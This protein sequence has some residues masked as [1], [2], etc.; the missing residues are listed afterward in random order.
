MKTEP[1]KHQAIG[2]AKMDGKRNFAALMEQGTGK[3][4]LIMADAERC[5][6]ANKIDALLVIAPNGVHTNWVK[7][8]I[9]T[10]MSIE[11]KSY[12]WKGTPTSKKRQQE[13]EDFFAPWHLERRRPLMV[14]SI[15]IDSVNTKHG[16]DV[17]ERFIAFSRTMAVVDEST[18]IKN[19]K[20]L[21]TKK[22]IKLGRNA[23]CRRIL[24]GT[25]M[26]KS[27][28]DLF[29]QFDFLK[30]G[31]L[32][33]K[34]LAAFTAEYAVLMDMDDPDMQAIMRNLAGKVHGMPQVVKKDE[35]GR[36]MFK[37]LARL[38]AMIEPHSYRVKKEDC[39]DLPPKVYSPIFFELSNKQKDV[40]KQLEIE[41]EYLFQDSDSGVEENMS[42]AAIAARTKMKQV[43]SGFINIYGDPVLMDAA[44]N[45]RMSTFIDLVETLEEN[46][47]QQQ[48]IV[49][50]MFDQELEQIMSVLN[51]M[52][53][54]CAKY[55]GDT[56]KASRDDIIDNF[57][58]GKIRAFV[59]NAAAGGIGI[60]LTAANTAIY[61]SCSYD[62]E[63]RKQ[64]EDRCHRIGTVKTVT[65]YDLIG[66]DTLDE[67]IMR[68]LSNKSRLSDIVIDGAE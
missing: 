21:R 33:T 67:D 57:Q 19:A 24:S 50:A 22:T 8:E 54:P 10:H 43:T 56:P 68:S 34:S 12:V 66:E 9:P 20:A 35:Y 27:P 16:Y 28:I 47:D 4:W 13:L 53:I 64:S 45:P 7:R 49:W 46:D 31:L 59:G 3:T 39:L 6:L 38:S 32:G 25:P 29:S 62:N 41:Y 36:P 44:D 61:Y 2:L 18:R 58:A 63:L 37:N 15:N 11:T 5:Y 1:M 17:I 30:S 26:P 65:Y 60:T 40:Y 14:F 42:F 55:A 52:G 23:T 51:K 48:F